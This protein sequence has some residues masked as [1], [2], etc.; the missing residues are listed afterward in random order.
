MV[1]IPRKEGSLCP[2]RFRT[3]HRH[4]A[5]IADGKD[6]TERITVEPAVIAHQIIE[7]F[8][9]GTLNRGFVVVNIE[10]HHFGSLA[11]AGVLH[12][13]GE[14]HSAILTVEVARSA[15]R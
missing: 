6:R 5:V 13:D 8:L 10:L 7:Q 11:A 2:F 15:K 12:I 3:V 1:K 4:R 14:S 9:V